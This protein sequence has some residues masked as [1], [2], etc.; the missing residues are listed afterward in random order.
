MSGI[1]TPKFTDQ[2]TFLASQKKHKPVSRGH[3]VQQYM[4]ELSLNFVC[5]I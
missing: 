5:D 1:N 2:N 3:E 4:N